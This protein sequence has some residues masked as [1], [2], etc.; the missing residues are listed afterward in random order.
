MRQV[1]VP[2]VEHSLEDDRMLSGYELMVTNGYPRTILEE[3]II[4]TADFISHRDAVELAGNMFNGY[5]FSGFIVATL[6]SCPLLDLA[7][8]FKDPLAS[9][10]IKSLLTTAFG[11]SCL[12]GCCRW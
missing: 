6:A 5:N 10:C 11:G 3:Y 12:S 7:N 1:L 8:T 4:D 9:L 2:D